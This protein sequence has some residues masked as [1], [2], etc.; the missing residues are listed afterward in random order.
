MVVCAMLAS[1]AGCLSISLGG[2]RQHEDPNVLKQTGS[3]SIPRGEIRE[4]YY[5][6][7]YPSP[8]NLEIDDSFHHYTILEQKADHFR[9]R[10]DNGSWHVTWT[11]R[12]VRVPPA[13]VTPSTTS[14]SNQ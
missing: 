4:V 2:W 12:G 1:G 11:A 3:V 7:P 8:P 14:D 5:P 9:I 10:N 6:V 13:I